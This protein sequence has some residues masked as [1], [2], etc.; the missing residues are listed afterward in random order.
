METVPFHKISLVGNYVKFRILLSDR[1]H[2][3]KA[4]RKKSVQKFVTVVWKDF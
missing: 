3:L 1:K 4:D 2:P